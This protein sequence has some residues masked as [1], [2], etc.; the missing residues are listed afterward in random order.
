MLPGI[1]NSQTAMLQPLSGIFQQT[2]YLPLR[3]APL[4]IELALADVSDPIIS[5]GFA[6]ETDTDATKF[7]AS[8]TSTLWKIEN[9]MVK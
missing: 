1:Q 7:K 8:N 3:Y 6:L 5:S 2:K 4:E 9:C